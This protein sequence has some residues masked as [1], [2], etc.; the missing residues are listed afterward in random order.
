[1]SSG[2]P[3]IEVRVY[4]LPEN[5]KSSFA[6]EFQRMRGCAFAFSKLYRAFLRF[7]YEQR[8]GFFYRRDGPPPPEVDWEESFRILDLED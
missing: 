3:E 7:A 1:M 2:C 5:P 6:I 8:P 4:A